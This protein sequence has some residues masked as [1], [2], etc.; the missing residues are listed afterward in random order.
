L[1]GKGRLPFWRKVVKC[2]FC[3]EEVKDEA[4]VCRYCNHNL[5]VVRRLADQLEEAQEIPPAPEPAN[6]GLAAPKE[7]KGPM[8]QNFLSWSLPIHTTVT[9]AIVTILLAHFLIIIELDRSEKALRLVT[10]LLALLFGIITRLPNQQAVLVLVLTSLFLGLCSV[11]LMFGVVALLFSEPM[12]LFHPLA[13]PGGQDEWRAEW[14]SF[15]EWAVSIALAFISGA[16][17]R[18]LL[19]RYAGLSDDPDVNGS[20]DTIDAELEPIV[21]FTKSIEALLASVA[22]IGTAIMSLLTALKH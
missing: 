14:R 6:T 16:T 2:P 7:W 19:R 20:Y 3:A 4:V 17:C 22:A 10:A 21:K 15:I 13:Y 11:F 9:L 8:L 1:D 18:W 5:T 12:L